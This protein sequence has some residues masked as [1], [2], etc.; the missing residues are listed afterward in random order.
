MSD[1]KPFLKL[2]GGDGNAFAILGKVQ[3]VA[4]KAGWTE[5]QI[6]EFME[7]AKSGDYNDLLITCQEYFDVH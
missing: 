7:E 3:R 6:N 1:K 5:E 4:N 2:S